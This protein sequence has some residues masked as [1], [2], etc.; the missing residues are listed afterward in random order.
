[1]ADAQTTTLNVTKS[2]GGFKEALTGGGARA[3][4]FKVTMTFPSDLNGSEDASSAMS[5]LCSSAQLPGQ[6]IGEIQV[7][8]RGRNLYVAGDRTFEAWTVT[9]Y[10]DIEFSVRNMF[11]MWMNKINKMSDNSGTSTPSGYQSTASVMQLNQ[12]GTGIMTYTFQGMWP[13]TLGNID[14]SYETTDAIETFD[15]T[16]RYNYFEAANAAGAI[17]T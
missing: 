1:M 13:T 14:V 12:A 7:P 3:N 5:F 15:C 2:I 6:T 8:F 9:C 17:T 10:N 4:R 11:E 16:F